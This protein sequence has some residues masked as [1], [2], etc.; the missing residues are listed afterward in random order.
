MLH[1]KGMIATYDYVPAAYPALLSAYGMY[2]ALG[3]EPAIADTGLRLYFIV[4]WM[5]GDFAEGRRLVKE[6]LRIY[7]EQGDLFGIASALA[8]WHERS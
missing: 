4:S 7:R 2:R 1:V 8:M 6:S 3:D 5:M